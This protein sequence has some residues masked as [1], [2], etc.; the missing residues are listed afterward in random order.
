MAVSPLIETARLRIE[1]FGEGHLTER[2]VNWLNDPDVVRYSDQ[3]FRRHTLKSCLGYWQSFAATPHFFWAVVAKDRMLG[4][5]GNLSAYVDQYHGVAD[6][7]ILIGERPAW[8]QGYGLEA[9]RAVCGY[10]FDSGVARKI[11]AGCLAANLPM[12]SI[13][14]RA[15]MVPDGVRIGHNLFEGRPMD[16]IHAAI[17]IDHW[18]G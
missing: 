1:P 13:M 5:I 6:L 9:W 14:S 17:F 10:L 3:R 4:H 15:G 8:R 11:S 7:G 12:M 2:Y 16:I 18:R